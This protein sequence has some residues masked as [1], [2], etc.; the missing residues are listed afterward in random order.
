[1]K[2]VERHLAQP[3]NRIHYCL[4]N[5]RLWQHSDDWDLAEKALKSYY[6]WVGQAV[7]DEAHF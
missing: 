4:M 5:H 7:D 3:E 6:H 2:P 1:M